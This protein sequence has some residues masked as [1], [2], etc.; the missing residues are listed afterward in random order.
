SGVFDAVKIDEAK[1]DKLYAFD[2]FLAESVSAVEEGAERVKA[3]PPEAVGPDA[4]KPLED[5]VATCNS[6]I[7]ERMALFRE[8]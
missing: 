5:Q 2:L 1:L 6:K 4:L 3:L 8:A 7:E